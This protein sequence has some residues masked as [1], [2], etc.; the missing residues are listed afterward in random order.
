MQTVFCCMTI[1]SR[2]YKAAETSGFQE[3]QTEVRNTFYSLVNYEGWK[4][5]LTS[6]TVF[7]LQDNNKQLLNRYFNQLKMYTGWSRA[8]MKD[9]LNLKK[10]NAELIAYFKAK[11]HYE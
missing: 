11:Y 6:S 4:D 3:V 1:C 2:K 9:L 7:T 5:T 10:R 8:R